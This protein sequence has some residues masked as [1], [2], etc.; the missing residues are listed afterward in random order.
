[1]R[2]IGARSRTRA[3]AEHPFYVV[4]RLWGFAKV[5]YRGIA[6]NLA[7]AVSLL[8]LANL[9]LVRRQLLPPTGEVRLVSPGWSMGPVAR[10]SQA[11]TGWPTPGSPQSSS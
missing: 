2:L 10:N 6:K 11:A 4:K 8:A 7:R 1:M 5:R 3:R 9:Y